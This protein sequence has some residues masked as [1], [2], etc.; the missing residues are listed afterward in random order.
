M[1]TFPPP[2]RTAALLA[3]E[4]LTAARYLQ[5]RRLAFDLTLED[6]AAA[7]APLE[8][9]RPEAAALVRML[10]VSGNRARYRKTIAS[11]AKIFP[12]DP[13]VYFQLADEPADRHPM[14]C[15]G[16]GCSLNDPCTGSQGVCTDTPSGQCSRCIERAVGYFAVV[17]REMAA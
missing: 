6:V 5:L 10:E 13:E 12:L 17:R 2:R 11:L 1:L 4:P 16:C 8:R 7:L 15:P 9:D 3:P 14:V